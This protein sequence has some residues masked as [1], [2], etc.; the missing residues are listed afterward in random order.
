LS[1]FDGS[2]SAFDDLLSRNF[3]YRRQT[4]ARSIQTAGYPG[5]KKELPIE[6][7]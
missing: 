3:I 1:A 6:I 7:Q 2:L 5:C 4:A